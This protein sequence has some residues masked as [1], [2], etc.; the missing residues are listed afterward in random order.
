MFIPALLQRTCIGTEWRTNPRDCKFVEPLRDIVSNQCA[1]DGCYILIPRWKYNFSVKLISTRKQ[2][3]DDFP[4]ARELVIEFSVQQ[5]GYQQR[6]A[7][8]PPVR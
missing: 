2:K 7:T 5:V 1:P 3:A 4:F 6:V 8:L